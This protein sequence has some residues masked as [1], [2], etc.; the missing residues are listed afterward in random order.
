MSRF[1]LPISKYPLI[2][3][4][5]TERSA[6]N[7]IGLIHIPDDV[8][9]LI[10]IEIGHLRSL[11]AL[12]ITCKSIFMLFESCDLIKVTAIWMIQRAIRERCALLSSN[13]YRLFKKIR[14]GFFSCIM[15]WEG[16][17]MVTRRNIEKKKEKNW[18]S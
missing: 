11:G 15:S 1:R 8:K 18:I 13:W 14:G 6:A 3:K 10:F 5:I 16:C 7:K 4:T 2:T 17:I 9:L 12:K